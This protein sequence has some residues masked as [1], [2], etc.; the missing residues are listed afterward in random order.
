MCVSDFAGSEGF[1]AD[2]TWVRCKIRGGGRVRGISAG[3]FMRRAFA[4]ATVDAA[5]LTTGFGRGYRKG[6]FFGGCPSSGVSANLGRSS[7]VCKGVGFVVPWRVRMPFD[8]AKGERASAIV[9]EVKEVAGLCLVLI[10]VWG[11]GA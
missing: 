10:G 3:Y 7:L 8:P 2:S 6:S 11:G 5:A 1:L 9:F 4:C